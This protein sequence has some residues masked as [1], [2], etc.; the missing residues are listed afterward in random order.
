MTTPFFFSNNEMKFSQ[1]HCNQYY[2]YRIYNF[3]AKDKQ[4]DIALLHGGLDE[5]HA[6]P[7]NFMAKIDNKE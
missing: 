3:K 2:L 4:A 5:N 1:E 7:I 6:I